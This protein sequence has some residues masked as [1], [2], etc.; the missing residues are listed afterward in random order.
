[1]EIRMETPVLF[2]R[3]VNSSNAEERLER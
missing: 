2:R 3:S 1:M